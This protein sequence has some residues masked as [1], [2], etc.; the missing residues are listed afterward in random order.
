[1]RYI[2]LL[3]GVNVGGNHKVAMKELREKVVHLGY[4]NVSTYLNSGNLLFES[5]ESP[6]EICD[7]IESLFKESYDFDLPFLLKS[8]DE[9]KLIEKAIPTDW[10][11]DTLYKT[12]VAYL[13]AQVDSQ[14]IIE[15]LPIKRE[16][17]DIHYVKGALF[18][19]V[20]RENYSKSHLN[21]IP[22]CKLYKLMTVRNIN[23]ARILAGK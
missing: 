23:T 3:R 6:K 16:Y 19:R 1:M 2:V 9:M 10:N 5:Q 18:W 8:E 20:E 21:K 11:N 15:R 7:K 14:E 12:D 17:V 4:S 13:F 22:S